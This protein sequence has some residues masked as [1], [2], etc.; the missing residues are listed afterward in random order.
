MY[1]PDEAYENLI[2]Y[3]EQ[4]EE[5]NNKKLNESDTRFKIIDTILIDVLGWDKSELETEHPIG[6][7][8]KDEDH[9]SLFADYLL[10]SNHNQF[11]IE[12][13]RNERYFTI[14]QSYVRTYTTSGV[15]VSNS[16]NKKFIEQATT[17]MSKI[18]TPFC[19]LC[20]GL[21]FIIIRSKSLAQKKDALVF[22]GM[23]DILANFSEFYSILSPNEV[24]ARH[25]DK[26]LD[27][28]DE[29][30]QPPTYS[31]KVFD[32]LI[33]KNEQSAN[34]E[35]RA[36]TEEY[37]TKYFGE[38]TRSKTQIETLKECYCDPTG[39]F[40]AFSKQLKQKIISKEVDALKQ[41][42]VKDALWQGGNFED[43]YIATLKEKE[44]GVFVLV[45][46]VGAGKTTFINHFYFYELSEQIRKDLIWV[47]ID[48]LEFTGKTDEVNNFLIEKLE[49]LMKT[50]L[51]SKYG[52]HK[53]DT[54][55]KIFQEEMDILL[56]GLPPYFQEDSKEVQKAQFE[57][58]QELTQNKDFYLKKVFQYLREELGKKI[59]FVFDN[60][61][62]KP[63]DQ[64]LEI[65]MNAFK[66]ANNY[67]A[68]IVTALRLENYFKSLDKPPFDAY[69]PIVF[70]IEPPSVK[71]LLKKRLNASLRYQREEFSMDLGAKVF[72]IP[73]AKFVQVLENTLDYM[74]ERQVEEML[75][76]LSG[77]N[78]RRALLIFKK[79][80]QAGNF[81]LYQNYSLI[82]R[83]KDARL[84]YE[85][86]LES[87][88]LGDNKYY[89]SQDSPL[90]NLFKYHTEDGFYSHFTAIYVLKFLEDRVGYQKQHNN[91]F[92]SLDEIYNKFSFMFASKEKMIIILEDL[93][94][95]FIIESNIGER[96]QIINTESIAI[97]ELGLYYLNHF[98]MDW[99]YFKY[100]IVDTPIKNRSFHRELVTEFKKAERTLNKNAKLIITLNAIEL[101]LEYLKKSE[102]EEF[103]LINS[104]LPS[105]IASPVRAIMPKIINDF[106]QA[107]ATELKNIPAHFKI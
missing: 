5:M 69:Q 75:E 53:W 43:K 34:S 45:G 47:N 17:Y 84:E 3:K 44:G 101:F 77:G 14:P 26:I 67:Q 78:M 20:N 103:K 70:R 71:E 63:N 11:L 30:R 68:I 97:S 98:L 54:K 100:V 29:I 23:E 104:I 87:V 8:K 55:L 88:A 37:I 50:D 60:T 16:D 18:G 83:L 57:K 42:Q 28:T 73:V 86:V 59:C 32:A 31:K 49:E 65:L 58:I 48:F 6:E 40:T 56:E 96:Q 79:F 106:N 81:V 4:L 9:K 2:K 74:P 89:Q 41:L 35:I 94:Q 91:G 27:R 90:K 93:L 39:K 15:L 36:V 92:V 66:Q 76:N 25:L 95:Q 7:T 12:A 85:E 13:K 107:K 80:I 82:K 19:V 99:N 105:G 46:G 72:K 21:Q 102:E 33:N 38:L 52:I 10:K 61:D 62:Q 24:G 51:F 64:Q 22:K 1:S